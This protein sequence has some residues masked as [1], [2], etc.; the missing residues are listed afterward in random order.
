M[1][2]K[3]CLIVISIALLL[4]ACASPKMSQELERGKLTFKN[5][6][7]QKAF[8]QLL[9]IAAKG[10]AE[11]QY[12][13]G[14]MYYYGYG[15][16][17]DTE[18]GIFWITKSAE[19]HYLPAI[20]ALAVLSHHENAPVVEPT[21]RTPPMNS[22][23]NVT[24]QPVTQG[25][26]FY[27]PLR[28]S[29]ADEVLQTLPMEQK[30]KTAFAETTTPVVETKPIVQA[31]AAAPKESPIAEQKT[32]AVSNGYTLQLFGA[33]QLTDVKLLQRQLKLKNTSRIFH[34]T[35]NGKDWYVLTFGNF[36]T[37]HEAVATKHN[38]P[39]DI[40]HLA[41]WVRTVETLEV[42]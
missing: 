42:V 27:A 4:Q 19:Q 11:A 3:R 31:Q 18:S 7:Y 35:H 28:S 29:S 36:A 15:V 40:G 32:S 34:T 14:Y 22:M 37:V 16:A 12:A 13:V 2:L 39:T 25:T 1:R 8:H 20:Q 26:T 17:E 6:E 33:Y 41:P 38:L 21:P 10:R 9:P 30:I 23:P 5:G 24:V